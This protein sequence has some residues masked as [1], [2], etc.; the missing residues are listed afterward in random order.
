MLYP[1]YSFEQI[2]LDS[3]DFASSGDTVRISEALPVLSGFDATGANYSWD[4][5]SLSPE[6]Q[7]LKNYY[8][9][10]AVPILVNFSMEPLPV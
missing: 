2:T 3:T 4:F 7:E 9:M 5:S 1:F 6:S 8:S 10:S